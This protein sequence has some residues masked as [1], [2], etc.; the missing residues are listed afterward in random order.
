MLK[1]SI[2]YLFP[3]LLSC[4]NLI[5][6]LSSSSNYTSEQLHTCSIILQESDHFKKIDKHLLVALIWEESKFYMSSKPNGS[7]CV[8]PFQ[9]KVS[10]WCPNKNGIWS[11]H[12]QD[13]VLHTCDLINRGLYAFNY[14]FSKNK[15]LSEK[16][17]L[18]GPAKKCKNYKT[19]SYSK[20]YV[21]A[22]LKN[23]KRIKN[24]VI[25]R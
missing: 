18:Y 16:I 17:C 9:I 22:V 24:H 2:L 6:E 1:I 10:Y 15:P 5:T 8:G 14:Y 23:L 4:H 20:R 12:K 7:N 19:S 13:G 3:Y 25:K 11:I 21:D